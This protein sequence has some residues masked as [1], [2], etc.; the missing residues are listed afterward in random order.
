MSKITPEWVEEQIEHEM[1]RG[2]T[3]SAINDLA[4]LAGVRRFMMDT[5]RWHKPMQHT[6]AQHAHHHGLTEEQAKE[7][8][9]HMEAADPACKSGGK[10]TWE[11]AR[12]VA[13]ERGIHPDGQMMIDFY[14]AL[15]MVY[16][17][18]CKVARDHKVANE[19][20]FADLAMAFLFDRD[21]IDPTDKICMYHKYLVKR[22]NEDF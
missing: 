19:D 13:E 1:E 12:R 3:P 9:S 21:G 8:V 14:A 7:W 10:W 2:T 17:D 4:A 11:S 22:E 15:N 16:S 20:F 5:G 18:Y 6:P